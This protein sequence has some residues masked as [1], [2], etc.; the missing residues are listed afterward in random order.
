MDNEKPENFKVRNRIVRLK[1]VDGTVINGQVNI[2]RGRGYERLSELV[3]DG[4][5]SFFVL[6]DA[7]LYDK[8]GGNPEKYKTLFVN[9]MHILWVEPDEDQ[10]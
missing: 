1:L 6:M 5:D 9:K 8:N 4:S 10:K 2:A 3:G 7:T